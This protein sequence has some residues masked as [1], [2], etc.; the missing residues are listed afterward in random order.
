[1]FRHPL[2]ASKGEDLESHLLPPFSSLSPWH[3]THGVPSCTLVHT[4]AH[5][6]HTHAHAHGAHE[7]THKH[8]VSPHTRMHRPMVHTHTGTHMHTVS[9]HTHTQAL[10]GD[11]SGSEFTS[12]PSFA[13]ENTPSLR[14]P[15]SAPSRAASEELAALLQPFPVWKCLPHPCP[16]EPSAPCLLGPRPLVRSLLLC[17]SLPCLAR[18]SKGPGPPLMG[19]GGFSAHPEVGFPGQTEAEAFRSPW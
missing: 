5:T 11:C 6:V 10:Q 13:R 3:P 4:Y 8:T 16:T 19:S 2:P 14:V 15:W 7:H 9:P 1:M 18:D 12:H 17:A